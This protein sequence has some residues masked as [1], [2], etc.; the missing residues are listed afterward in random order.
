MKRVSLRLC[1]V[2]GSGL[3]LVLGDENKDEAGRARR[4]Y[5]FH[6]FSQMAGAARQ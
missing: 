4:D 1:M 3:V 2:G 5:F 6:R